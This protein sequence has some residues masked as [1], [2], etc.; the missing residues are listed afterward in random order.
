MH[1]ERLG[2]GAGDRAGPDLKSGMVDSGRSFVRKVGRP[3]QVSKSQPVH[4][5]L[6]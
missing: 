2:K 4:P 3:F 6:T 5:E 1:I